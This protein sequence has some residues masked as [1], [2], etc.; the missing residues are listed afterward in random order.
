MWAGSSIGIGYL[1][2]DQIEHALAYTEHM[3]PALAIFFG[4]LGTYAWYKAV[5]RRRQLRHI[6]RITVEELS[7]KLKTADPPLLIDLRKRTDPMESPALP[8][9]SMCLST[10]W[11]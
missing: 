7:E 6:P 9:R 4:A 11:L 10:N 2:S 8:A 3:T 5:S 1:F